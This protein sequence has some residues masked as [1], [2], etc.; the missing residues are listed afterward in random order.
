MKAANNIKM[1]QSISLNTKLRR[2]S[3]FEGDIVLNV[4]IIAF[5]M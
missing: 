2:P 4:G 5:Y 1:Q 3:N